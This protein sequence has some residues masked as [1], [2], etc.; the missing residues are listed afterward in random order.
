MLVFL[1]L[2]YGTGHI[3]TLHLRTNFEQAV[4]LPPVSTRIIKCKCSVAIVLPVLVVVQ[5][6]ASPATTLAVVSTYVNDVKIIASFNFHVIPGIIL[7]NKHIGTFGSG[8]LS[9][10]I[11]LHDNVTMENGDVSTQ[12]YLLSYSYVHASIRYLLLCEAEASL[13]LY[14]RLYLGF[15]QSK[16]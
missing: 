1:Y 11:V 15:Y 3:A 8:I 2:S 9:Y 4:M 13:T 10:I 14:M 16:V 12:T 6:P 5:G 7:C